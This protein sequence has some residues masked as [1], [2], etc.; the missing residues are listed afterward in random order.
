MNITD[1]TVATGLLTL[2]V[3]GATQLVK[4]LFDRNFRGA[5]IIAV[6][7]LI[8]GVVGAFVLP[9]IGFA[10]GVVAGLSAA[11]VVTTAQNVGGPKDTRP[12]V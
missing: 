6:A 9:V 3:V 2:M 11:G 12:T 1:V 8:G 4:N 7:A 10:V 5:V